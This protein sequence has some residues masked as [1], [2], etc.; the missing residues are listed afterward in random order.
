LG[1]LDGLEGFAFHFLHALWYRI[2]VDSKI[3]EIR[4]GEGVPLK[5]IGKS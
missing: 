4:R 1:F 2:L 3:F 5:K